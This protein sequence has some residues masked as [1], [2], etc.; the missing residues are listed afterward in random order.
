MPF[1]YASIFKYGYQALMLNEYE[2]LD[3]DCM[4]ESG[5]QKCDPLTTFDSPQGLRASMLCILGL[6]IGCY[7]VAWMIMIKLSTKYE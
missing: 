1:Q 4:H 5:F 3:I 6:Y 2:G 7:M